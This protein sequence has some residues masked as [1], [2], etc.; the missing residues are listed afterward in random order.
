MPIKLILKYN[1]DWA[2]EVP[3]KTNVKFKSVPQGAEIRLKKH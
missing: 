3:Q 2:G 1:P